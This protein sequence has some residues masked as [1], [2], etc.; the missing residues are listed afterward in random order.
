MD[1]IVSSRRRRLANEWESKSELSRSSLRLQRA[2]RSRQQRRDEVLHPTG[3]TLRQYYRSPGELMREMKRQSRIDRED[4]LRRLRAMGSI[5][6]KERG[7]GSWQPI[8]AAQ[9]IRD[10]NLEP[11]ALHQHLQRPSSG[12]TARDPPD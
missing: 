8:A 9:V 10:F 7:S 11:D 1:R 6:L 3:A 12:R 4:L 5:Y 2:M